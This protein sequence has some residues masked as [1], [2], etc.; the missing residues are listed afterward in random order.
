MENNEQKA[1]EGEATEAKPADAPTGDK[2]QT[3][4]YV[5]RAINTVERLEAANKKTEELIQRQE[6]IAAQNILGGRSEG[7]AQEENKE[8]T[9]KDYKDAILRGEIPTKE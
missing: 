4:N 2:Q 8:L 9:N 3:T 1:D 6:K 7:A 5:D